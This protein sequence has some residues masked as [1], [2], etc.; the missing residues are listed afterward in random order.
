M[1]LAVLL[2]FIKTAKIIKIHC[3][4]E[5]YMNPSGIMGAEDHPNMVVIQNESVIFIIELTVGFET[6]ID[7]NAK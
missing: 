1:I 7:L 2:S 4:I 5:G 6:N 3:Y